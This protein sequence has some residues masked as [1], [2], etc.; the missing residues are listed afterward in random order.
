MCQFKN[1]L[2]EGVECSRPAIRDGHCIF[3]ASKYT[4]AEKQ[5][6]SEAEMAAEMEFE[7]QF[8]QEFFE[9]LNRIE[10]SSNDEPIDFRG[11]EFP[12]ISL[13][14]NVTKKILF[15]GAIFHQEVTFSKITFEQGADFLLV[16]FKG[17]ADFS[18]STFEQKANFYGVTFDE[19]LTA[20]ADFSCT[21]FNGDADFSHATFHQPA[22]F[23]G[24]TFGKDR[25]ASF[26]DVKF[27]DAVNFQHTEFHG[28][29]VFKADFEQETYFSSAKFKREVSFKG[30]TFSKDKKTDFRSAKF[31]G[32]DF[33]DITFPNQT[34]FSDT[35]YEHAATF[36]GVTFCEE[37]NFYYS[38]FLQVVYFKYARFQKGADFSEVLFWHIA[39]F[40]D[41]TFAG[42][43]RFARSGHKLSF[44]GE[45]NII[46]DF[47]GEGRFRRLTLEDGAEVVFDKVN[48]SQATFLDTNVE[49]F[50]FRDVR[51]FQPES[52]MKRWFRDMLVRYIRNRQGAPAKLSA[53][54]DEED[55]RD[56]QQWLIKRYIRQ[57]EAQIQAGNQPETAKAESSGESQNGE[58]QKNPG[59]ANKDSNETKTLISTKPRLTHWDRALY[60]FRNVVL[61]WSDR[62]S[63]SSS[64]LSREKALWDE[65]YNVIDIS[66][67]D[68]EKI[69]ENYRQL[70][71]NYEKRREYDVAENF[72]FGEMHM[73]RRR[74]GA[75]RKWWMPSRWVN[76]HSIYGLSSSYGTSYRRALLIFALIFLLLSIAFQYSGYQIIE[77][78]SGTVVRTIEYEVLH[79]SNYQSVPF[80]QWWAD[81][82]QSLM[83]TLTLITFQKG[84]FYRPLDGLSRL[85][86][87]VGTLALAGQAALLFLAI[88]RR[89]KR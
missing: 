15:N 13:D 63:S 70:V 87:S 19:R 72:H 55:I 39:D 56:R 45:T 43:T 41:A 26:S 46:K 82:S 69:A 66:E 54:H 28:W 38:V 21:T 86:L 33:S 61:K 65:F 52:R 85:W 36:T 17:G 24:V 68:Y 20:S 67:K 12:E 9:L 48:L 59:N 81:F 77:P 83:F 34:D 40:S 88:R 62:N 37:A 31:F 27:K 64:G 22:Y 1:R 35:T 8:R 42:K 58:G 57:L 44:E 18:H 10:G 76:G 84:D 51:W 23:G 4:S 2:G 11:F 5:S 79:K 14:K 30:S 73:R 71:L 60:R 29:T 16:R 89:F 49:D 50:I 3:H 53:F 75:S 32:A 74:K 25:S 47:F 78:K 7:E 80:R 6:F